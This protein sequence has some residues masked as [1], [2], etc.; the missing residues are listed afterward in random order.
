MD[1]FNDFGNKKEPKHNKSPEKPLNHKVESQTNAHLNEPQVTS[2]EDDEFVDL[3][4]FYNTD[5]ICILSDDDVKKDTH[6]KE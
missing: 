2:I 1:D 3:S 4:K 5:D 6:E